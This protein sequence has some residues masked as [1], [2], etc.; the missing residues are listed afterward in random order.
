MESAIGYVQNL[1]PVKV[2]SKR[3]ISYF[4]FTLQT[5]CEQ[6]TRAV[7]FHESLRATLESYQDSVTPVK[8][9]N[10]SR[11]PNWNDP[12][13][14]DVVVNNRSVVETAPPS[15][16]NF[17]GQSTAENGDAPEYLVDDI[18]A[19]RAGQKLTVRG[20]LAMNVDEARSVQINGGTKRVL[21]TSTL[22]DNT[23][24]NLL[25]TFVNVRN[26][27]PIVLFVDFFNVSC[28]YSLQVASG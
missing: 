4:E 18:R 12:T 6:Y 22:T 8:L 14:I 27:W 20:R 25:V 1:S 11:R 3:K 21:D 7:C 26:S 24:N 15:E 28:V 13:K 2:G 23:G 10:I 5:G 17:E 16:V 19:V 9:R